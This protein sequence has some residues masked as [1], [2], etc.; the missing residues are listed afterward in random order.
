[1]GSGSADQL[2]K[3]RAV[4]EEAIANQGLNFS[5]GAVLFE[6]YREFETI[7]YAQLQAESPV[8]IVLFE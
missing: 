1:M 4:F 5:Q 3:T 7:R 6:V 8:S 2:T